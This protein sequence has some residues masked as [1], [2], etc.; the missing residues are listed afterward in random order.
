MKKKTQ[1]TALVSSKLVL[2]NSSVK[3]Q[4]ANMKNNTQ[5]EILFCGGYI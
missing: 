4:E 3:L 1:H 5:G 2:H